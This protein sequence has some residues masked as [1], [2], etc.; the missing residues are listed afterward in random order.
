MSYPQGGQTSGIG[1]SDTPEYTVVSGGAT[2]TYQHEWSYSYD[3]FNYTSLGSNSS[4]VWIPGIDLPS[5]ALGSFPIYIRVIVTDQNN[6]TITLFKSVEATNEDVGQDTPCSHHPIPMPLVGQ[7][8]DSTINEVFPNPVEDKLSFN[9][10][11]D[12]EMESIH[13][14]NLQGKIVLSKPFTF[15]LDVSG[16]LPGIYVIK[17]KSDKEIQTSKFIKN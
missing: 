3:G 2:G 13:V 9:F 4:S 8:N 5:T 7:N 10:M 16:L 17:F 15:D 11:E 1:G 12:N 14:Y 6:N